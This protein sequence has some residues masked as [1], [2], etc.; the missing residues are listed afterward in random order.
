VVGKDTSQQEQV[1]DALT[2]TVAYFLTGVGLTPDEINR[3]KRAGLD[4][5]QSGANL[6]AGIAR[7]EDALTVS[8]IAVVAEVTANSAGT[9]PIQRQLM[10][11]P[12]RVLKGKL[13][14][15]FS[16]PLR[17]PA[18]VANAR[19]GAQYLLFLSAELG[20]FQRAAGRRAEGS[21]A[22]VSLPYEVQGGS[23][24]PVSPGQDPAPR[25]IAEIDAFAAQ[26][27]GIFNAQ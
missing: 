7:I 25:S 12:R 21:L 24:V 16:I 22:W 20:P 4:P 6:V 5:L 2:R 3:L 9:N 23:Y 11:T 8:P 26:H 17:L 13:E 15:G 1:R 18:P 19:Q 27:A 14:S 10:F